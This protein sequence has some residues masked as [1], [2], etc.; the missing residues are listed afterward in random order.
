M[1][2]IENTLE[3]LVL[4]IQAQ[5]EASEQQFP[6]G[7]IPY[8]KLNESEQWRET[9]FNPDVSALFCQFKN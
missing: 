4:Q 7:G 6:T 5:K 3:T 8:G 1:G 9:K 2:E